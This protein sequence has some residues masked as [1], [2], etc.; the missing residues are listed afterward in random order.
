MPLFVFTWAA[1]PELR[2]GTD[3]RSEGVELTPE[4]AREIVRLMGIVSDYGCEYIEAEVP[5]LYREVQVIGERKAEYNEY[6]H[7]FGAA[8]VLAS[9]HMP[10]CSEGLSAHDVR[11]II[12]L[13]HEAIFPPAE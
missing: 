4:M 1:D 11:G 2:G 7:T 12:S 6:D 9:G 10:Y 13:A 5:G 8:V 3:A